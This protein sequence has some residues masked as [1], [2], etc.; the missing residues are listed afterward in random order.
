[1]ALPRIALVATVATALGCVQPTSGIVEP[2]RLLNWSP[3]AGSR[4]VAPDVVVYATFST[5][6]APE[7]VTA[8]TFRLLSPAGDVAAALDYDQPNF[9]IRLTPASP[10]AFGV[11]HTVIAG[12]GLRSGTEGSFAAAIENSFFTTERTGCSQGVECTVPADC[13]AG[14]ICANIGV[15]TSECVTDRDCY[16]GTCTSGTGTCVFNGSDSAG[17]GDPVLPAGDAGLGDSTPGDS[18]VSD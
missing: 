9:T 1:M 5:D 14:Q 6:L 2:L 16:N 10:L 17:G 12:A 13:S 7:S 15:C 3:A 11:L 8:E 18:L 4:C